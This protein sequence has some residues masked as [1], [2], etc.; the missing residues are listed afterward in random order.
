VWPCNRSHRLGEDRA[1]ATVL[2]VR[3]F[4]QELT[5]DS[6]GSR[7]ELGMARGWE[8]K[9][10]EGQVQD[11]Q[12]EDTGTGR[13][14]LTPAQLDLRRRRE[15]LLLSKARTQRDLELSKDGRYREMLSRALAD[16]DAQLNQLDEE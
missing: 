7:V 3:N 6:N 8:S 11:H 4:R 1:Q 14:T 12:D 16:L 13:K 9:A 15:V 5:R 2:R 10:V